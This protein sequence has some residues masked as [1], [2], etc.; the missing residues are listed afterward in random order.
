M[1]LP[2]E[3]D[4]PVAKIGINEDAEVVVVVLVPRLNWGVVAELAA[5]KGN[6]D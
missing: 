3:R 4:V 6:D 5:K 1:F 2:D